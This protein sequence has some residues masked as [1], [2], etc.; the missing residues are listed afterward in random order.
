MRWV[1]HFSILHFLPITPFA[2]GR[3]LEQFGASRIF[4]NYQVRFVDQTQLLAQILAFKLLF[5]SVCAVP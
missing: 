4:A 5:S 2:L 1:N 3:L